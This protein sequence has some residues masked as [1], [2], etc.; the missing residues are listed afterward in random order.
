[1]GAMFPELLNCIWYVNLSHYKAI[2]ISSTG[3]GWIRLP[4]APNWYQLSAE[5]QILAVANG[6]MY[7][8]NLVSIVVERQ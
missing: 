2:Q 8:S 1:M 6:R 3:R 7:Q 4:L 5:A